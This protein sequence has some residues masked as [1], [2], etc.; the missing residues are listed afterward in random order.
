MREIPYDENICHLCGYDQSEPQDS[1]ALE[2]GT[3]LDEGRYQIGAVIGSGGFGI[4]YA[5]WDF[6][7][8]Q[9]A[10]IKEYFP[11][12]LCSRDTTEDDT[13]TTSPKTE[14][15]YKLGLMRFIREARI[16]G[17]LQ[18]IRNVDPV[19]EYFQANNTAY[20]V[21]KYVRGI[22]AGDYVKK[23]NL[24]PQK[25]IAIMKDIVDSLVLV[26]SQGIL[27]RDISPSNIMVEEDGNVTLIDFGAASLEERRKQGLD[28]TG[29]YNRTYAAPEQ[30]SGSDMEQG[31]WTD[32]YELSATIYSLI[33]GEAPRGISVI[34]P[35]SRHIRLKK[36]QQKAIMQGLAYRPQ[37]RIKNME[38]FRSVLYNLPLPEEEKRRRKFMLRVVSFASVLSLSVILGVVNLTYGFVLKDGV[39]YSMHH[40]GLH[41][42]GFQDSMETLEIPEKLLGIR[43]AEISR[44]AFQGADNLIGVYVPESVSTVRE[45]AFNGCRNLRNVTLSSGVKKLAGQSFSGCENLQA[46]MIPDSV[47]SIEPDAFAGSASRLVLLGN[48]NTPASELAKKM[49]ISYAHIETAENDTGITITKYETEQD[50]ISVPDYIDGRPVT[51]IE[52][53]STASVFPE[54]IEL[55]SITLPKYLKRIGDHAL[56]KLWLRNIDLPD[57]LEHIGKMAFTFSNFESIYLPDSVTTLDERAFFV[58]GFLKSVRFSPNI[59]RIPQGCFEQDQYLESLILPEGITEIMPWA[60]LQCTK[61]SAV[62][63]PDGLKTIDAYA[64]MECESLRTVY[65]PSSLENMSRSA[66]DGCS[67]SLTITG[68]SGT[69][70]ESVCKDYGFRFYDL[71]GNDRN[72]IITDKGEILV[73]PQ[74]EEQNYMTLPSY[75][76]DVAVRHITL[77]MNLKSKHVVFPEHLESVGPMSFKENMYIESADFPSTLRTIEMQAFSHCS[78]LKHVSLNEGLSVIESAAFEQCRELKNVELP[79]SLTEL[80]IGA[81]FRCSGITSIK[82]PESMVILNDDVFAYTGLVS[83]TVPG[84][85]TKCRGAFYGCSKLKKA[86][87]KEGVR[88]LWGT[89]SGCSA[90]ESVVLPS[91]V[92][93]V[94]RSTFRGCKNLRDVWIYSDDAELDYISWFLEHVEYHGFDGNDELTYPE[95]NDDVPLFVDTPDVTIH[96]HKGST[97]EAY[98][99]SHGLRFEELHDAQPLQQNFL[100]R[101]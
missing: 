74:L 86:V 61:L 35:S 54:F 70:A 68:Y 37:D 41:V 3:L 19:L 91:T 87:L 5:A 92:K 69:I 9:P 32:V 97:S 22:T 88:T 23:N 48:M 6:N 65:L 60:F 42:R 36:H 64:F 76:M 75:S 56:S 18:N 1:S 89:F 31:T 45:F 29:I 94:S 8:E 47:V 57:S 50:T 13:I 33:C 38:I 30:L 21:M 16:L 84:N 58:C 79:S 80:W 90:L 28:R 53:G 26:H 101:M 24:P 99:L 66:F 62:K 34:P 93:Q 17:T 15:V 77:A 4:T 67:A 7:L 52:S 10:A 12:D 78:N 71:A 83:V 98:A 96:A 85:I 40:D 73:P 82:I 46:V 11:I 81:F 25:V 51:A 44:G 39:R 59:S 100:V 63:I 27:H 43:V 55:R 2:E 72:I 49:N 20:I 14:G 95:R